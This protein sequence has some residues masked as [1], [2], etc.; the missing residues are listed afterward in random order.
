MLTLLG[1]KIEDEASRLSTSRRTNCIMEAVEAYSRQKPLTKIQSSTVTGATY[2]TVTDW[3]GWIVDF[4]DIEKVEYPADDEP[5]SY[6]EKDDFYL[7]KVADAVIRLYFV[8]DLSSGEVFRVHYTA[9]HALTT[10]ATTLP[11]ND[12]KAI[13]N[14]A[15]SF[16]CEQLAAIFAGTTDPTITS[17]VV[18]YKG[19]G[20]GFSNLAKIYQE[21]YNKMLGFDKGAMVIRDLDTH[22]ISGWQYLTRGKKWH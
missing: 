16:A 2:Y 20:Q 4:S 12:F 15:A 3:T 8:D 9:L 10:A 7:T 19:K 1:E 18:D 17:D 5:A 14:L 11:E 21:K 6:L 13:A 22:L